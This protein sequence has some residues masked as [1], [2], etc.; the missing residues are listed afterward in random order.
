MEQF[1]ATLSWQLRNVRGPVRAIEKTILS[2]NDHARAFGLRGHVRGSRHGVFL[3]SGDGLG[4]MPVVEVESVPRWI[5][6]FNWSFLPDER[7]IEDWLEEPTVPVEPG[8]MA[9][10]AKRSAVM[11][12]W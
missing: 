6:K 11:G 12:T 8:I 5:V 3:R 10:S 4:K 2:S 1:R 9:T 7:T